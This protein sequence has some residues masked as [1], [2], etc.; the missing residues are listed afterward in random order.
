MFGSRALTQTNNTSSYCEH[1]EVFLTQTSSKNLS[2]IPNLDIHGLHY[3]GKYI[4]D[5][6]LCMRSRAAGFGCRKCDTG[7]IAIVST[8]AY[9]RQKLNSTSTTVANGK[10]K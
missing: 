8:V 9:G 7:R 4:R 1:K 6:P 2:N 3:T 5:V 10:E